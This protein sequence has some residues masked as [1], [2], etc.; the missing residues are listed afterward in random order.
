MKKQIK[1]CKIQKIVLQLETRNTILKTNRKNLVKKM[2]FIMGQGGNI[3][4]ESIFKRNS[5]Q[6]IWT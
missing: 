6:A 3:C 4:D 2:Y 1:I 5:V